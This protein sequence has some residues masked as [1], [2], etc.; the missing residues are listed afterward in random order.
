[1]SVT[2]AVERAVHAFRPAGASFL[3]AA[4]N[5]GVEVRSDGAV[6]F[7]PQHL[8]STVRSKRPS[9]RLLRKSAPITGAPVSLATVSI[10]RGTAVAA[11]GAAS[12]TSDGSLEVARELAT[13]HLRDGAAGLEQSWSFATRPSGSEDLVVRV[14]FSG[15]TFTSETATG[16]HFVDRATGVGVR[17]GVAT[18]IDAAGARTEVRPHFDAGQIVLTVPAQVVE[19]AA[20]PAV[21]DP[22]LGSEFGIDTPGGGDTESSPGVGASGTNFLV[23]WADVRGGV[24]SVRG[25]LVSLTGALVGA[26]SFVISTDTV[27]GSNDGTGAIVTWDGNTYLCTWVT[28][29]SATIRGARVNASTAAVGAAF[30]IDNNAI[31]KL[32]APRTASN[33]GGETLVVWSQVGP[34]DGSFEVWG[35]FIL[36]GATA[37]LGTSFRIEPGDGVN[38]VFG[39]SVATSGID[40]FVANTDFDAAAPGVSGR[41]VSAATS[42]VGSR[43]RLTNGGSTQN[44][45]VAFDGNNYLVVFDDAR[46]PGGGGGG[47][48]NDLFGGRFS[49]AAGVLVD[50]IGGVPI[51]ADSGTTDTW[52]PELVFDGSAYFLAYSIGFASTGVQQINLSAVPFGVGQAVASSG[53]PPRVATDRAG[54]SLVVFPAV[55]AVLFSG[56]AANGTTCNVATDCAS[57]NCVNTG[58]GLTC[59]NTACGPL[60]NTTLACTPANG[61]VC[62]VTGCTG[63][64]NC[65][66]LASNGCEA[67][68]TGAMCGGCGG[69]FACSTTNTTATSCDVSGNCGDTC[70]A[71]FDNCDATRRANGCNVAITTPAHCGSCGN[72]CAAPT[73]CAPTVLCMGGTTC[74]AVTIDQCATP[75]C[76][77]G[78]AGCAGSGIDTDGDGLSDA[79]ENNQGIDVDCNGSVAGA[80]LIFQNLDP[81]NPNGAN[82]VVGVKDVY[83]QYDYMV[84]A[85]QG[86]G[87]APT[88]IAG[89]PGFSTDCDFDQYCIAGVCR[90][91]S[92]APDP[93]A[94]AMVQATLWAH[95]INL[96]IDPVHHALTSHTRV[97]S[98]GPPVAGCAADDALTMAMPRRAADFYTYKTNPAFFDKARRQGAF[99]YAI[100]AHDYACDSTT[101]CMSTFCSSAGNPDFRASGNSEYIGDD[102]MIAFGGRYDQTGGQAPPTIINQAATI[103]HELGHNLGLDHGG[104]YDGTAERQLN[105]KP[106]FISV[107]NYAYQLQGITTADRPNRTNCTSDHTDTGA[108]VACPVRIDFQDTTPVLTAAG[109]LHNLDE[110][111]GMLNEPN[112]VNTGNNDV[113]YW[114][115]P[116]RHA[117]PGTGPIDFDFNGDG[118][119]EA[120]IAAATQI[121]NDASFDLLQSHRDWNALR[122]DFQCNALTNGDGAAPPQARAREISWDTAAA[123]GLLYPLLTENIDLRPGCTTNWIAPGQT[124]NVAVAVFGSSDF[125]ATLVNASTLRFLGVAATSTSHSDLNSDGRQDLIANF[126]MAGMSV[127]T[128][129]TNATITGQ[130][131]STQA[132]QG[133]APITI[134]PTAGPVVTIKPPD[135]NGYEGS[136]WPPNGKQQ[137]WTLA[138]CVTSA[139]DRCGSAV[140]LTGSEHIVKITSD[141]TGSGQAVITGN[142]TFTLASDRDGGGNGRV[143]TVYYTITDSIGDVATTTCK[144]EVRHDNGGGA[145]IDSGTHACTGTCP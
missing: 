110:H 54:H 120:P 45:A 32:G 29:F 80:E 139:I 8:Q 89:Y 68:W 100:F 75:F 60:P 49:A 13:E 131:N 116:G 58:G 28:N 65:D 99:H 81:A 129:A 59:C 128:G 41:T 78:A 73:T 39:Q 83:L 106:N 50:P 52:F 16:L 87:C 6:T 23:A 109:L 96:H 44:T 143:Y 71:G 86:T 111:A 10:G 107:M 112:G 55:G 127:P 69:A 123:E 145:A 98:Y 12:V 35:V 15:E 77:L 47:N 138:A 57:G 95:G 38:G 85:D 48:I 103:L 24:N 102:I 130:L 79:W 140:T 133:T 33:G 3:V 51:H 27:D 132:F 122:Y 119:I 108:I 31:F 37:I 43:V 90:G 62:T 84:L 91:H 88:P 114:Y 118:A 97:L 22:T 19:S 9:L 18:F 7:R 134:V 93:A 76:G 14:A 144:F 101:N 26:D 105:Y 2:S 66:G 92:D 46:R 74:K 94:I 124:G 142:S 53:S 40:F 136:M 72:V 115:H 34:Q 25:R 126:P 141:E 4:G 117:G 21:L 104:P 36:Q 70:A 20:F 67:P 42:L 17:Y 125:N 61:G 11:S 56:A 1:M 30:D 135:A 5:H 82:P 121:N 137:A 63:A 64:S 113:V